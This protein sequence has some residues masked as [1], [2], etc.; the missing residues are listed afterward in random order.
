MM[1]RLNATRR[2]FLTFTV[3]AAALGAWPA[4]AE[5]GSVPSGAVELAAFDQVW[6]T[7]RDR[8]YDPRLHGLDWPAVRARYRPQAASAGSRE[9]AAAVINAMLAELRASHTHYYTVDDPAFYQ[10]ADIFSGALRRRGLDRVFP[11]GEVTYPG[12]GV[13]TEADDEGRTFAT[14]VIEGAPAHQ[15]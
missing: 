4:R 2:D 3:A 14:G 12:I 15:A 1:N 9:D 8:F 5:T 11:S 13:F 7:V 10:L 6:E